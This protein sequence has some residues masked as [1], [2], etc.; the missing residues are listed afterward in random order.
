MAVPEHHIREAVAR[1]VSGE[2][3]RQEL[4]EWFAPVAW[5][6]LAGAPSPTADL[7]AEME[8]AFAES[9]NEGWTD[10]QLRE[11][12]VD[13]AEIPLGRVFHVDSPLSVS[14]TGGPL[15]NTVMAHQ[16]TFWVNTKPNEVTRAA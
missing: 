10:S 9:M 1:Y 12:L 16:A 13:V 15:Q 14:A 3:G 11:R 8:L 6:V 2:I 7:A 5:E 4:Q